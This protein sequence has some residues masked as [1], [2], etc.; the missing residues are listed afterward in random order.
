MRC[1]TFSGTN[2]VGWWYSMIFGQLV[3]RKA[4]VVTQMDKVT[5]ELDEC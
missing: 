1:L 5:P 4:G 3:L 2:A